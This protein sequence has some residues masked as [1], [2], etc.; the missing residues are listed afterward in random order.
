MLRAKNYRYPKLG[1][2][3][4]KVLLLPINSTAVV[5]VNRKKHECEIWPARCLAYRATISQTLGEAGERSAYF[6][7]G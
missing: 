2:R 1:W 4:E 7:M 3:A 5:G 6:D